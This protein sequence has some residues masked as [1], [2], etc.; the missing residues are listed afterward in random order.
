MTATYGQKNEK[1]K[2]TTRKKGGLIGTAKSCRVRVDENQCMYNLD[3]LEAELLPPTT[4]AENNLI[5]PRV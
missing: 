2:K 3:W 4:M 5:S 1:E